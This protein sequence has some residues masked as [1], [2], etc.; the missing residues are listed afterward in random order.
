MF[1]LPAPSAAESLAASFPG[2]LLWP[3]QPT[4]LLGWLI[5]TPVHPPPCVTPAT[6]VGI[7]W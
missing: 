4:V 2:K 1:P 5:G 7:A 3:P 6:F